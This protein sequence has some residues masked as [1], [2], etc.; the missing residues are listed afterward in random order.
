MISKAAKEKETKPEAP[1]RE[2]VRLARSCGI[3]VRFEN[4]GGA[5]VAAPAVTLAR[6]VNALT[7]STL[8]DHPS[9]VELKS[10]LKNITAARRQSDAPRVMV[11]WGGRLKSFWLW[12]DQRPQK[13]QAAIRTEEGELV[14]EPG[15]SILECIRRGGLWRVR[16]GWKAMRLPEGYYRLE[17]SSGGARVCAPLLVSA[18]RRVE[19]HNKGWGLFVPTYA[20]QTKNP[21][22]IG[23]FKELKEAAAQVRK[24]GGDFIGTLPLLATAYEGNAPDPS[25]YAPQSRLFWNEIFLD[26]GEEGD[27]TPKGGFVDYGAA[28]AKKRKT[29]EKKAQ[30]FFSA[31]GSETP[32]F[33]QFRA[34]S[35]YLNDYARFR[36][37]QE[38]SG[39]QS[40][41]VQFHEYVQFECH[42]QLLDFRARDRYAE[43]YLDY[44][45]GVRRDGFDSTFF[46]RIF[47]PRVQVGAPPD[48]FFA[49][50]QDWGFQP[51]HPQRLIADE[52]RYFRAT[53]GN[54]FRYARML[55][56][57]HIM[58]LYRLYCIPEGFSAEHGAYVHY[59]FEPF[60]AVLCLEAKRSGGLLAGEDLGTV[61]GIVRK[62]MTR[63]GISRMWV[64]QLE[65]K[66]SPEETF[67]RIKPNMIASL[68][69]HDLFP[70][71][72]YIDGKDIEELARLGVLNEQEL[73]SHRAHRR[74]SL[75]RWKRGDEALRI[76]LRYL[77]SSPARRVIINV[78]DLWHETLPQNIP[79]TCAEYANWRRRLPFATR[80]WLNQKDLRDAVQ[81]LNHYR[82]S[83]G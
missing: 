73:K 19:D 13:M 55:R 3:A 10:V 44:P 53:L 76:A 4:W 49:K 70:F 61:P 36:A 63:H 65:M 57:D 80:A 21:S 48:M 45:I 23:G 59:P 2:L 79:G 78:E 47:M 14:A 56:L 1:S 17:V 62:A 60:L 31:G 77:A 83:R 74:K 66:S 8:S 7:G 30:S 51:F 27:D 52:F 29:L 43:L 24:A 58:G 18:P 67:R 34:A 33:Q 75:K 11:A 12:L 68:N 81:T 82:S 64:A 15:V 9:S 26:T 37:R 69:T 5:T 35:P 38:G 22:G 25:P 71:A 54:Y 42:R 41:A 20:L 16:L 39:G 28:Y 46:S 40:E 72:A 50:G 6:L 32:E